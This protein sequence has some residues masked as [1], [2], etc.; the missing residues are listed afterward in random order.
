MIGV[1]F[2]FRGVGDAGPGVVSWL[3]PIGWA[4]LI[5]MAAV[6]IF[7]R[8]RVPWWMSIMAFLGIAMTLVA[9]RNGAVAAIIGAPIQE[10]GWTAMLTG[11]TEASIS[12]DHPVLRAAEQSTA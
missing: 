6:A 10:R 1:A 11:R 9:L 7:G 3:S 8:W 5:Y 4:S 2:F 12:Q